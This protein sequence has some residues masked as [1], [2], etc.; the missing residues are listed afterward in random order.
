MLKYHMKGYSGYGVAYS[1]F[2]DNKLAVAS[3]SNF[4]LVGNGKL[5]ILDIM[6][7]GQL[8]ESNSFLTQDGLFDLAWNE[9]HEN[10]CLVAQGD[11]S[12]RL[13]DIK[14]KDYPIAIYKEHQREVFS[15]I[16]SVVSYPLKERQNEFLTWRF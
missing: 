5:I 4:G 2:Y 15:L 10:Q 11:G 14:L 6:P 8:V 1:P 16:Y 7:N 13:F 9:S 12:L 3:G